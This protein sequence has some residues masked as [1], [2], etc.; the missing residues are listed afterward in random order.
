MTT[1]RWHAFVEYDAA[2]DDE[3]LY[4]L[5]DFTIRNT[6]TGRVILS[7]ECKSPTARQ[8][9]DAAIKQGREALLSAGV[10]EHLAGLHVRTW[11]DYERDM[12]VPQVPDLV[13]YAEIGDLA[14]PNPVS[15]QR[16]R[17]IAEAP[18]FPPAVV[19]PASGPLYVKEQVEAFFATRDNKPGPKPKAAPQAD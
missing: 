12:S 1:T 9:V 6:E 5:P 4:N 13:G 14:K 16:A 8:A 17:A 15:R 3:Q 7:L 11:E 19:R 18:G 2:I 10:S